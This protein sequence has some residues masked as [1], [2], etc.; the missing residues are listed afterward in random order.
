MGAKRWINLGFFN[1]QPSE[2]FKLALVIALARYFNNIHIY[3]IKTLYFLFFP[4]IITV[5]PVYLILR[6]PDLGTALILLMT[7]IMIIFII[8]T[9]IKKFIIAAVCAIFSIPF[10]GDY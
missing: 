9:K 8:G 7:A 10:Y 3:K 6:Q 5:I 2:F 4:T 1:L